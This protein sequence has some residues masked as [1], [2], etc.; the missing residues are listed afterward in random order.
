M[1]EETPKPRKAARKTTQRKS[2]SKNAGKKQVK[3]A[4]EGELN[5]GESLPVT[6][7]KEEVEIAASVAPIEPIEPSEPARAVREP[8]EGVR[9][10]RSREKIEEENEISEPLVPI[11]RDHSRDERRAERG[12]NSGQRDGGERSQG[13][14][15]DRRGRKRVR[16]RGP[17]QDSRQGQDPRPQGQGNPQESRQGQGK[18][19]RPSE[20]RK[21]KVRPEVDHKEVAEK[22]WKIYLSEVTEE[23]LVLLDDLR[24]R[25]FARGSFHAARL[26]L[27]EKARF[28]PS[29]SGHPKDRKPRRDEEDDKE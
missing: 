10:A 20:I 9:D 8:K 21:E 25:E 2:A 16:G 4:D 13:D 19:P 29:K 14:Q 28:A 24:L 7:V 1:S 15:D 22:A 3:D 5:G 17:G 18:E 27:E 12:P 23:G 6:E 26:F 11:D